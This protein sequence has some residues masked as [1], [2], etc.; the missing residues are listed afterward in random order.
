MVEST[1]LDKLLKDLGDIPGMSDQW[2]NRLI[3]LAI[4]ATGEGY[5]LGYS[6][7]YAEGEKLEPSDQG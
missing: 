5:K 2:K 4:Q 7:G 6:E 3:S 1:A